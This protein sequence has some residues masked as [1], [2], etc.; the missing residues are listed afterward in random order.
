MKK[1][2]TAVSFEADEHIPPPVLDQEIWDR[3]DTYEEGEESKE[4][5]QGEGTTRR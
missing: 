2:K 5:S 3:V 4:S 1:K